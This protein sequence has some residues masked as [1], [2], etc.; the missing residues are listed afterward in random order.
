MIY[1]FHVDTS[2]RMFPSSS[3]QVSYDW[4]TIMF[5][6]WG[7]QLCLKEHSPFEYEI[8]FVCFFGLPSVCIYIYMLYTFDATERGSFSLGF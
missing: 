8:Q 5:F 7:P 6:H 2:T 1:D 3:M 4:A